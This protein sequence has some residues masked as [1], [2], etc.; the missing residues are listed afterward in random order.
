MKKQWFWHRG[1]KIYNMKGHYI[2]RDSSN[3]FLGSCDA[4]ELNKR[5]DEIESEG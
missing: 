1:Y 4:N 5:I 2:I 3:Q